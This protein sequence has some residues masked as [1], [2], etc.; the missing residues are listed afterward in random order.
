[1][2]V[3]AQIMLVCIPKYDHD[4]RLES[5]QI[6]S[7]SVRW[8]SRKSSMHASFLCVLVH[9]Y[10][11]LCMHRLYKSA[12]QNRLVGIGSKDSKFRQNLFI[13]YQEND[14]CMLVCL[15]VHVHAGACTNHGCLHTRVSWDTYYTL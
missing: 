3:R 2:Q 1:M 10:L 12:H 14:P 9:A 15:N 11:C 6:S 13:D 7:K 8:L 5:F 4:Y